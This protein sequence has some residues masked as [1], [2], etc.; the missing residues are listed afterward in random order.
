MMT[1]DYFLFAFGAY[2]TANGIE[3][4]RAYE[5]CDVG[6]EKKDAEGGV[7]A[8]LKAPP[9]ELWPN[10]IPTVRVAEWIRMRCGT[11]IDVNSGYRDPDYNEAVGGAAKSRHVAFSAMD[12]CDR[13]IGPAGI[14]RM[15]EEH[16]EAPKMGIGVY[17]TFVHID[18]RGY[19]ARW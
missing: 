8:T 13:R 3:H 6:R 1:R 17:P 19:K 16:P 9:V 2:L 18:T 7:V 15:L 10:I 4:F 14:A 11:P 12:I 5:L